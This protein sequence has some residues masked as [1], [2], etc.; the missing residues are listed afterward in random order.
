MSLVGL[1][2]FLHVLVCH[3]CLHEGHN[4]ARYQES[5]V[6]S[7]QQSSSDKALPRKKEATGN[8]CSKL[9]FKRILYVNKHVLR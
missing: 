8:L 7:S 3:L 5:Q 9:G 1:S 6:P 2:R 4:M